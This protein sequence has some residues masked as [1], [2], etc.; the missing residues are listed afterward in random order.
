LKGPIDSKKT[1]GKSYIFGK[2]VKNE[3]FFVFT[4]T[5]ESLSLPRKSH[6]KLA[7]FEKS[8]YCNENMNANSNFKRNYLKN[9]NDSE[10]A[11]KTKNASFFMN[12]PKI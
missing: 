4:T 3:A 10:H 6:L 9:D 1:L 5:S 12:F 2:F 7:V 8:A 11:V